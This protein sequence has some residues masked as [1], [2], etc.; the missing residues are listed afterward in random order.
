MQ[1]SRSETITEYAPILKSGIFCLS[2]ISINH[3][4]HSNIS[5]WCS[6]TTL[7]NSNAI[8]LYIILYLASN[9]NFQV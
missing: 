9:H 2:D 4:P 1:S 5:N 8:R 6:A 3:E 7:F